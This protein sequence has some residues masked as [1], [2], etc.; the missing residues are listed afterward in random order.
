MSRRHTVAAVAFD[1]F[2]P[3]ELSVAW[4]VF[5]FDRSDI[6]DPWYRFFVCAVEGR[7]VKS[8][9]GFEVRTPYGVDDLRKADTIVVPAAYNGSPDDYPKLLDA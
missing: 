5:G 9:A 4:E 6:A 3:F 8:D 1:R 2:P 7:P